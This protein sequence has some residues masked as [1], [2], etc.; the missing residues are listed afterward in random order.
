MSRSR[1]RIP[2]GKAPWEHET[3]IWFDEM[4]YD[5]VASGVI[6]SRTRHQLR[7]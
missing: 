4:G 3:N 1:I 5:R 7:G 2:G 6:I